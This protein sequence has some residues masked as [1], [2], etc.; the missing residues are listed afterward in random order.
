MTL[1]MSSPA[2]GERYTLDDWRQWE[3]DWELIAGV[4]YAMA[5]SPTVTHQIVAGALFK[6]LYDQL[7][8]CPHC[9]AFYETDVELSQDTVVRPDIQL[10]CYEPAGE[11]LTRAPELI[12]EVV[13]AQTS[14]RDEQLKFML[15]QAEGVTYYLLAYPVAR[16]IKAWRLADGAYRKLGDYHDEILRIDLSACSVE[17][18]V[19]RVWRR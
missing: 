18:D 12:V 5:P 13:S 7:E 11:R 8:H 1:S 15:Y 6:L 2:Y 19:A 17:L 16:K 14:R 9:R 3:G 10:I 4:P